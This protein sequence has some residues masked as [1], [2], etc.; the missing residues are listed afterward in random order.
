M[1]ICNLRP[2]R[3]AAIA[4]AIAAFLVP[5]GCGGDS[6]TTTVAGPETTVTTTVTA[7]GRP[8]GRAKEG[9]G[10][11]PEAN[12]EPEGQAEGPNGLGPNRGPGQIG[13]QGGARPFRRLAQPGGPLRRCIKRLGGFQGGGSQLRN[14]EGARKAQQSLRKC[15]AK[16][17]RSFGPGGD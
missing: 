4:G 3:A 2:L 15:I 16:H 10:A 11:A 17:L 9:S 7:P 13:R 6:E 14:P 5:A 1:R 12:R 8:E